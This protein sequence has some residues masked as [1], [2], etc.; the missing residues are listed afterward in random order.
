MSE[1]VE[2]K[3]GDVW[4]ETYPP[5]IT[6]HI[7][8][9]TAVGS[10]VYYPGTPFQQ[11]FGESLEKHIWFVTQISMSSFHIT[12]LDLGMR[13]KKTYAMKVDQVQ[14]FDLSILERSDV[15][16][17]IEG[18]SIEYASFTKSP[19]YAKLVK[20]KV[21]I[22]HILSDT[23]SKS[24]SKEIGVDIKPTFEN[25]LDRLVLKAKTEYVK[26]VHILKFIEMEQI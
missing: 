3:D 2:S 14:S 8:E 9:A 24:F 15:R 16:I 4:L 26:H 23:A 7:H 5:L 10:N 13:K 20:A 11:D 18:S 19:L 17:C 25:V 21:K 12:K 6:G 1:N 22:T